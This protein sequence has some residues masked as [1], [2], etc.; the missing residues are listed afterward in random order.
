M[1]FDAKGQPKEPNATCSRCGPT[2]MVF[3]GYY[4]VEPVGEQGS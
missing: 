1:Q 2:T 4:D 3:E